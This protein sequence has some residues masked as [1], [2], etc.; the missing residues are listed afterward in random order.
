MVFD[1]KNIKVEVEQ[2][3]FIREKKDWSMRT[4]IGKKNLKLTF[5]K[6]I[7]LYNKFETIPYGFI[8]II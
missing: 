3:K 5:D 4:E 7:V 2:L 1:D 8:E 6:R